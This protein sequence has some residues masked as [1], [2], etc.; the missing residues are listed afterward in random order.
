MKF[1]CFPAASA[2]QQFNTMRTKTCSVP[3]CFS[4]SRQGEV[5]FFSFPK[6]LERAQEWVRAVSDP[7]LDIEKAIKQH[8]HRVVCCRHFTTSQ[9]NTPGRVRLNRNAVPTLFLP[10]S[11]STEKGLSASYLQYRSNHKIAEPGIQDEH[12]CIEADVKQET[13][14]LEE[15]GSQFLPPL[16]SWMHGYERDLQPLQND[17]ERV[18][19]PVQE[20]TQLREDI[21]AENDTTQQHNSDG[22][23]ADHQNHCGEPVT[24]DDTAVN[25]REISETCDATSD[26]G[27]TD[28][29]CDVK[30]IPNEPSTVA[31]GTWENLPNQLCR[32][33]A[34]TDEHPKQSVVGWL[35]LLKEIIP[36]LVALDDGL[37]QHICQPCAN[38]LYTCTKIKADFIEAY[39]K[40]QE[41]CGYSRSPGIQ[42]IDIPSAMSC[43]PKE[44]LVSEIEDQL[45]SEIE[46]QMVP[47]VEEQLVSEV[48]SEGLCRLTPNSKKDFLEGKKMT[49]NTGG[50]LSLNL[51]E[52]AIS[53]THDEATL[54]G[55]F[56][57]SKLESVG[58]T[59]GACEMKEQKVGKYKYV[60]DE[61]EE[62]FTTKGALKV[63][64]LA[65]R[66]VFECECCGKQCRSAAQIDDHRRIHTKELPF[67]CELCG[68]CFRTTEQLRNHKYVHKPLIYACEVCNKKCSSTTFLRQHKKVHCTDTKLICEVCGKILCTPFSFRIHLRSHT[69]EK[70]FQCDVCGK[71]FSAASKLKKHRFVHTNRKFRSIACSKEFSFKHSLLQHEECH[72]K[73]KYYRCVIC[74]RPYSNLQNMRRHRKLYCKHIICIVCNETFLTDEMLKEHR[75]KEHTEEEVMLA[76]KSYKRQQCHKCPLCGL[77]VTGLNNMLKHTKECH[78]GYNYK[79]FGCEECS[80]T[81]TSISALHIHVRCHRENSLIA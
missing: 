45:V 78:S 73:L 27:D 55:N 32:L 1:V 62:M 58:D 6:G 30:F 76:A 66:K 42:F 5:T 74:F 12:E 53:A 64:R 54:Q 46:E 25:V 47:E 60:C 20:D 31:L 34:S 80:K 9:F 50:D 65:H 8:K 33:C 81:F 67:M 43:Y 37:P 59:S 44:Q 41:S 2:V 49:L 71:C 18:E 38:K 61:C 23:Q 17:Q 24:L 11:L 35:D 72:A 3:G 69:G 7:D 14:S 75:S 26:H 21:L 40:L 36:D 48:P 51:E 22:T 15:A 63:H 4:S 10:S 16:D 29:C 57:Q 19:M 39:N 79:P 28:E 13:G 68:K 77:G 52:C 56:L 70:P